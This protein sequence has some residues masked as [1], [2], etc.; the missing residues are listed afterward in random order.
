MKFVVL[1]SRIDNY[2]NTCL[3]AQALGKIVIGPRGSS[4]EEMIIDGETG[5]LSTPGSV[6]SL[7]AVIQGGLSL[8]EKALKRLE[9]NISHL[10]QIRKNNDQISALIRL[11][12]RTVAEFQRSG[13]KLE[14][15]LLGRGY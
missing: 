10:N 15:G 14:Q 8:S 5:F 2:P 9:E 11:Y 3:E 4:L 7:V 1:P 6:E 13:M 12:Q